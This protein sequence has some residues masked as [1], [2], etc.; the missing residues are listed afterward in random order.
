MKPPGALDEV[1]LEV[2]RGIPPGA[3]ASYG[4]VAEVVSGLGHDCTA[5]RVA[6][7][8][9]PFGGSV[10]WW[11]VV[12]AAGTLAEPVAKQ[13]ARLLTDEGVPVSGRRVPLR[14]RRWV[15]TPDELRAIDRRLREGGHPAAVR[16]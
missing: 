13:A 2:V 15:P 6:R 11:R 7:T 10:A 1:I 4:D 9:S 12:Q 14:A 8:V 16:S 3:L 5:R